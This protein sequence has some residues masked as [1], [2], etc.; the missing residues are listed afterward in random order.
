MKETAQK[1]MRKVK[2]CSAAEIQIRTALLHRNLTVSIIADRLQV[3]HAMIS[4]LIS[5]KRRSQRLENKLANLIG[6]PRKSLWT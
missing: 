6:I 1:S 5:G 2:A 3:S 4:Q